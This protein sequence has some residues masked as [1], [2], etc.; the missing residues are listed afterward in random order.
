VV[1]AG[2]LTPMPVLFPRR[3]VLARRVREFNKH[4]EPKGTADRDGDGKG[5]GGRFAKGDGAA[6]D[7]A[8]AP[9]AS[10]LPD[11]TGGHRVTT[12]DEIKRG[13]VVPGKIGLQGLERPDGSFD[14][15][16]RPGVHAKKAQQPF[17]AAGAITM[18]PADLTIEALDNIA[19]R[20]DDNAPD[21]MFEYLQAHEPHIV[22]SAQALHESA[23]AAFPEFREAMNGMSKALGLHVTTDNIDSDTFL[24][25][26]DEA[27]AVG[28]IKATART[29]VKAVRDY[30]GTVVKV[31]DMLRSSLVVSTA[32]GMADALEKLDAVMDI[33][34][35][36]D[37]VSKP[38][39]GGWRAVNVIARL[40][41]SG[42]LAEVQIVT[43]PMLRAKK[44]GHELYKRTRDMAASHPEFR[45][46]LQQQE[47]IYTRAWAA[48][49]G[50]M[51]A[52]TAIAAFIANRGGA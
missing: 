33:E 11:L 38:A 32:D 37:N 2:R 1:Q 24:N 10:R 19:T 46:L 12:P 16:H 5:D 29:A 49:A 36:K 17:E 42:M 39:A 18:V 4:H 43:K 30:D 8:A 41:E 51:A 28:P 15:Y 20:G 9:K 21:Q 3:T 26:D 40:R 31:K 47:D 14:P 50:T 52:A 7:A 23:K 45:A 34:D 13:T 48:S 35:I 6:S 27:I 44:I 25:T 22:A